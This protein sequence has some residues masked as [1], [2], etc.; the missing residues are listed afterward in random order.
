MG[1]LYT[2]L[3]R[4]TAGVPAIPLYTSRFAFRIA[5]HFGERGPGSARVSRALLGVPPSRVPGGTPGTACGAQA[6]PGPQTFVPALRRADSASQLV[7][8]GM[9]SLP[10][11]FGVREQQARRPAAT[12]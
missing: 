9:A 6:L 1:A 11:Q 12:H 10:V 4:V 7:Y 3:G 5:I 8:K 2:T